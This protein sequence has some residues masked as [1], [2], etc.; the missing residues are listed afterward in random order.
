MMFFSN[1]LGL[2][3]GPLAA[4][5]ASEALAPAAGAESVRWTLAV[6]PV[7]LLLAAWQFSRAGR[8]LRESAPV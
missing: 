8:A 5:F 4:G 1:A 3:L 7:F 6:A 2:G